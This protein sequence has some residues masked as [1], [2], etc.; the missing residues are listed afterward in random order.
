[1]VYIVFVLKTLNFFKI[2]ENDT[3]T[4]IDLLT[5]VSGIGPAKAKQLVNAGVRTIEDLHK[6]E[7]MLNH[8]QLIGLK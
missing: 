4:A 6:H 5:H 8:H 7:D 1:M 2:R 3:S